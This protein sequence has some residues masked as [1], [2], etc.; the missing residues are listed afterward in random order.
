MLILTRRVGEALKLGEDITVT[1][2]GVRG[3]QVR[4]GIDAPK[5]VAIQREEI[6]STAVTDRTPEIRDELSN[7]QDE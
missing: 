6:Y 3:N 4:I 1:V 5:S 7:I 2:L